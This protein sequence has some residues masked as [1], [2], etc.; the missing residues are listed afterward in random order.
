[1]ALYEFSDGILK[2]HV[3]REN[4]EETLQKTFNTEAKFGDNKNAINISNMKVRKTLCIYSR[5]KFQS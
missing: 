3:T 1:M 4:V 2:T 5:Y